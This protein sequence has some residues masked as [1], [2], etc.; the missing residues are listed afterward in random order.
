MAPRPCPQSAQ[1]LEHCPPTM[2][3]AV[4]GDAAIRIPLRPR[5]TNVP[6]LARR[7]TGSPVCI[8]ASLV[9]DTALLHLFRIPCAR[10]LTNDTPEFVLFRQMLQLLPIA[11][12]S[13]MHAAQDKVCRRKL[14]P[15]ISE[16]RLHGFDRNNRHV[17]IDCP[18]CGD[19]NKKDEGRRLERDQ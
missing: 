2:R 8:R 15:R 9:E 4:V 6:M 1:S 10:L 3:Y 18:L 14:Q 13:G 19:E 7:L 17:A 16:H 12:N 11:G 5:T